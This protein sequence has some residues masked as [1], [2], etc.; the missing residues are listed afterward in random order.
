MVL[1]IHWPLA[2]ALKKYYK[3]KTWV[4]NKSKFFTEV[5]FYKHI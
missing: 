3:E 1:L 4:Q 5:F 2:Q